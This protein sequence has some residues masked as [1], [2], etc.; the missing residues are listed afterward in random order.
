VELMNRPHMLARLIEGAEARRVASDPALLGL[1]RHD[2][3]LDEIRQIEV[4]TFP[5]QQNIWLVAIDSRGN[6]LVEKEIT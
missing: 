3:R 4:L 2:P 1:R 5:G 6:I